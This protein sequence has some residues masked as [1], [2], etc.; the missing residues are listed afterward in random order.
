MIYLAVKTEWEAVK[1]AWE[2]NLSAKDKFKPEKWMNT[3]YR[4]GN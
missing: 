3:I 2:Q 1:T 4:Y